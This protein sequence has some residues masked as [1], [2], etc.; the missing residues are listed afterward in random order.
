MSNREYKI[1]HLPDGKWRLTKGTTEA[2]V[3]DFD[4]KEEALLGIKRCVVPEIFY[5]DEQGEEVS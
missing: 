1:W 3:H 4:S 5:Y 2:R